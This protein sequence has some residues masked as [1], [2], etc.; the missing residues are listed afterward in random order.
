MAGLLSK[1]KCYF[2][3]LPENKTLNNNKIEQWTNELENSLH[4]VQN[5]F[6]SIFR[7]PD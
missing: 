5:H 4:L 2:K 7:S 3:Q 1:S 6:D